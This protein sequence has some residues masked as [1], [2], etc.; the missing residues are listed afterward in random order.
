MNPTPARHGCRRWHQAWLVDPFVSCDRAGV[1]F[2]L[3]VGRRERRT[4]VTADAGNRH[5]ALRAILDGLVLLP[6]DPGYDAARLPWNRAVTQRPVAVAT[7][8]TPSDVVRVVRAARDAGLKVAPQSTGHSAAPLDGRLDGAILL[9]MSGLSGVSI[10]PDRQ[11]ARVDG[12]T[13][14]GIVVQAAAHHGLAA[15]HGSGPAVAVVGYTL[16]GGLSWYARMHGLACN[17]VVAAEIVLADGTL[18]RVDRDAEPDLFWALRGGG[19]S[20]GVVTALEFRL[21]PLREVYAGV[22]LWDDPEVTGEVCRT[23]ARWTHG[24]AKDA[25]TSLRLLGRTR[26]PRDQ[27]IFP[28]R[29]VVI[30][31]GAILADDDRAAELIAPLRALRPALDTFSPTPTTDIPRLHFDPE[32]PSPFVSAD[33]LMDDFDDAAADALLAS[34]G[35]DSGSILLSAEVRHLGGALGRPDPEGGALTRIPGGYMG[36]FFADASTPERHAQGAADAARSVEALKPWSNGRRFLNFVEQ[37]SDPA[38]VFDRDTLNRLRAIRNQ[39]DPS[40]RFL[41]NHD[42]N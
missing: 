19:G 36:N 12:G 38:S 15:L 33:L 3:T 8:R 32:L 27:H 28:G 25:T 17:K 2:P 14:W 16:G 22:L 5:G 18:H 20:F 41:P 4:K 35:P 34:A 29:Q 30:I 40:R 31:D 42:L 11:I 9:R 7:P 23:W 37:A 1:I 21:L 39:V 26:L 24:L 10:D 13:P 6:E